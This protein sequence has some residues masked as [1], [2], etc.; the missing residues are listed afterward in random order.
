[1]I[2]RNYKCFFMNILISVIPCLTFAVQ[3][4]VRVIDSETKMPLQGVK[5]RGWFS[6]ENGWE[7]WTKAAPVYVDENITDKEG[8]C[9]LAGESNTGHVGF[10]IK[11]P[12]LQYYHS[13]NVKLTLDSSF[14]GDMFKGI[15]KR[16]KVYT[17]MLDRRKKP[18]PLLVK[19]V[20]FP[21]NKKKV[22]DIGEVEKN[23]F[24]YDFLTQDWLPPWGKGEFADIRFMRMPR[25]K[26]GLSTNFNGRVGVVFKDVVTVDFPGDGN[27]FVV[28]QVRDDAG[29]KVRE[30]PENGYSQHY[31]L[32]SG[33]GHDLQ[34]YTKY[35]KKRCLCFR[36]RT[37]FDDKGQIIEGYYGKIYGDIHHNA[38]KAGIAKI[39]FLY[40]L[41]PKPL[42]RNLE[43]DM[44]NNLCSNPGGLGQPMP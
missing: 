1:M 25:K 34:F 35:N 5:I 4:Q 37:R 42:D 40:Y 8:Y 12:P 38:W 21:L 15:F 36:I 30:A 13:P 44:K 20:S 28:M 6:N 7:A 24:A 16:D 23:S 31:E 3:Y 27:G 43:W 41:N 18:I 32:E 29:L 11:N 2:D 39:S 33:I 14:C 19:T 9:S 10:M 17:L 22:N 26:I